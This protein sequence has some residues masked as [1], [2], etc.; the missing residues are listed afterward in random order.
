MR[1]TSLGPADWSG[2]AVLTPGGVWLVSA[3]SR[4][5]A[6]QELAGEA[7]GEDSERHR[8]VVPQVR[9]QHPCQ[10]NGVILCLSTELAMTRVIPVV[11]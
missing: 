11:F 9:Q 7:A 3:C 4:S 2:A 8:G 1:L 5:E 10:A 6:R